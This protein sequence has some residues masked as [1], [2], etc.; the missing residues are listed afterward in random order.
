MP[1]CRVCDTPANK[2]SLRTFLSMRPVQKRFG[3]RYNKYENPNNALRREP[4]WQKEYYLK[5]PSIPFVNIWSWRKKARPPWRNISGMSVLFICLHANR[6]WQKSG[7]WLIKSIWLKRDMQPV[8]SIPCWRVLT[9]CW[10]SKAGQTVRLKTSRPNVRP[11]A[12]RK[13]SWQNPNTSGC[14][15]RQR[16]GLSCIWFWKPFAALA[17]V[18]LNCGSLTQKL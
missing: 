12:R 4:K 16:T 1:V 18:S 2:T 3:I 6:L 5:K 15:R 10:T 13:K 7:W 8:Q 9:V 11:T 17:F 14:R